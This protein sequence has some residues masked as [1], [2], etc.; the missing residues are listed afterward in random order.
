MRDG[1][2]YVSSLKDGRTVYIDGKRVSDV[3][4]HP[5]FRGIVDTIAVK[6]QS[7]RT[8]TIVC[9]N[10]VQGFRLSKMCNR[11]KSSNPLEIEEHERFHA[12][13]S[14]VVR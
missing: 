7:S 12:M 8:G 3:T 4:S 14:G 9:M 5:A 13:E 10:A 1:R 11:F 6:Y 2:Q